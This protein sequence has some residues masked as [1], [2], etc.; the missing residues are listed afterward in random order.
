MRITAKIAT[1]GE[2]GL[3]RFPCPNAEIDEC[4]GP[5][6][7][8]VE[9]KVRRALDCEQVQVGSKDDLPTLAFS[10]EYLK[11]MRSVVENLARKL[12]E[13]GGYEASV[14]DDRGVRTE[15][16]TDGDRRCERNMKKGRFAFFRTDVTDCLDGI[17]VKLSVQ[18]PRGVVGNAENFAREFAVM[19]ARILL[20]L[21]GEITASQI[22]LIEGDGCR[23]VFAEAQEQED[24]W[25]LAKRRAECP[26]LA[27]GRFCT[28][29]DPSCPLYRNGECMRPEDAV[30]GRVD[31][32]CRMADGDV[33]A[34]GER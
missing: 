2:A 22:V 9:S 25:A 1:A 3:S 6:G 10:M 34:K 8:M 31:R 32:R 20:Y 33:A 24:W 11:Q 17:H 26:R 18:N 29:I 15:G 21:K 27:K 7:R 14:A 12:N 5:D 13:N 16:A 30:K 19:C 4:L 28:P 23:G